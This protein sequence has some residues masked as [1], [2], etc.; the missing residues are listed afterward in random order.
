MYARVEGDLS[1]VSICG[2]LGI[3]DEAFVEK[4]AENLDGKNSFQ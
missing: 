4:P 3:T 2:K 1:E